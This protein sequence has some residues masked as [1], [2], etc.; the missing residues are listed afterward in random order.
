MVDASSSA[1]DDVVD[2]SVPTHRVRCSVDDER[3]PVSKNRVAAA[4]LASCRL[5]SAR[6]SPEFLGTAAAMLGG[7]PNHGRDSSGSD[8]DI[9]RPTPTSLFARLSRGDLD[10]DLDRDD[11]DLSAVL[12]PTGRGEDDLNIT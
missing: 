5:D 6:S 3:A 1:C 4:E 10:L 12:A 7:P 2:R 9:S 8:D 11:L